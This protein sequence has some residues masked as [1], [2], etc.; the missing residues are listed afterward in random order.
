MSVL[1]DVRNV[2]RDKASRGRVPGM[3]TMRRRL[4]TGPQDF[5]SKTPQAV[6]PSP[7]LLPVERIAPALGGVDVTDQAMVGPTGRRPLKEG[8]ARPAES[9]ADHCHADY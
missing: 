5:T 2:R 6:E 9:P 8:A 7:R 3:S 1:L 4:G